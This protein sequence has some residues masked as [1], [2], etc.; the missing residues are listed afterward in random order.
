MQRQSQQ[1]MQSS[2]QRLVPAPV[3]HSSQQGPEHW[4]RLH[5]THSRDIRS[6][7]WSNQHAPIMQ[8]SKSMSA[9]PMPQH[10][11]DT[12]STNEAP[13]TNT[14]SATGW[15]AA[16]F[17]TST[18]LQ[19]NMPTTSSLPLQA[20]QALQAAP[21][22]HIP[23]WQERNSVPRSSNRPSHPVPSRNNS[24]WQRFHNQP[25]PAAAAEAQVSEQ[26]G[27]LRDVSRDAGARDPQGNSAR[28]VRL[29]KA[30]SWG[31]IS[32]CGSRLL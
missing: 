1:T 16:P 21:Q 23:P 5:Q 8:Q 28:M 4:Q 29:S 32:S 25:V 19:R 20:A 27:E 9:E 14:R 17:T 7:T 22:Q 10:I 13:S 15:S 26:P 30:D 3:Q 24:R 12:R 11:Y 31:H 2:A 6:Q 18:P